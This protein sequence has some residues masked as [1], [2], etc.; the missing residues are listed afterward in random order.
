MSAQ[1]G[2]RQVGLA[3]GGATPDW[4]KGLRLRAVVE[5]KSK[6]SIDTGKALDRVRSEIQDAA[7]TK[8]A[9]AKT[10]YFA[11]YIIVLGD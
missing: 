6:Q 4:S 8:Q 5:S 7:A 11:G 2:G 1:S 9:E 10:V 3:V